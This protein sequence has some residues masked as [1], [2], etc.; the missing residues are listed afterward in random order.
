MY[1]G[2]KMKEYRVEVNEMHWIYVSAETED[3]AIKKAEAEARKR[4]PDYVESVIMKSSPEN[5]DT[6]FVFEA[7]MEFC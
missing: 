2:E 6:M 3:D 7:G 1:G 4:D 5:S